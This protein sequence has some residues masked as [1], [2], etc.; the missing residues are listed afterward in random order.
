[1]RAE[2]QS[3]TE[4]YAR[5]VGSEVQRH[6][7][8]RTGSIMSKVEQVTSKTAEMQAKVTLLE[9]CAQKATGPQDAEM[10]KLQTEQ[11]VLFAVLAGLRTSVSEL[12]HMVPAVTTLKSEV[13]SL[14]NKAKLYV[15]R[16]LMLGDRATR[17]ESLKIWEKLM[18]SQDE[19][20]ELRLRALER[21]SGSTI[22]AVNKRVDN[23]EKENSLLKAELLKN[24]R[25]SQPVQPPIVI[26]TSPPP[27]PVSEAKPPAA[28]VPLLSE[29]NE[30]IMRKQL[31]EFLAKNQ[32]DK[33]VSS[34]GAE[35][36]TEE[37]KGGD[38][39]ICPQNPSDIRHWQTGGD[40]L[41]F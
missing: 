29:E 22:L 33:D 21:E 37:G 19:K 14:I 15:T 13:E 17:D 26:N 1:M 3:F 36:Q 5:M 35:A 34:T 4:N 31:F 39:H 24:A 30:E 16:N 8:S 7:V 20:L 6:L 2:S 32:L 28:R 38:T 23:L 18:K 9:S 12:G 11:K 40:A 25:A 41:L 10:K 27:P